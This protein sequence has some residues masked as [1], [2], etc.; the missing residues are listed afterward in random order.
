VGRV[1]G[2]EAD[3]RTRVLMEEN[4]AARGSSRLARG[5]LK[6]LA[7]VLDTNSR[8]VYKYAMP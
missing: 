3:L 6:I 8:R 7:Q 2:S 4:S 1:R 5:F